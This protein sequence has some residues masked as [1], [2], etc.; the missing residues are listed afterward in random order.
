MA[1][2]WG[3]LLGIGGGAVGL[4]GFAEVVK[5]LLRRKV[6]QAEAAQIVSKSAVELID[7]VK[8][9]AEQDIARAVTEAKEARRDATEARQEV[10][11]ARRETNAAR[12]EAERAQR[13]ASE[14]LYLVQRLVGAIR[15]PGITI[16][17][18]LDL[19]DHASFADYLA[20]DKLQ[21]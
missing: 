4:Y 15:R 19:I 20:R 16:E 17:Q 5:S 11:E 7:A 18:L 14:S 21:D 6:T 1:I 3:S 9:S 8:K 12:R 2:D 10:S 13:A